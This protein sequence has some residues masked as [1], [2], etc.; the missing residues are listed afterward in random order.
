M[1]ANVRRPSHLTDPS[2]SPSSDGTGSA[3]QQMTAAERL[4]AATASPQYMSAFERAAKDAML[5]ESDQTR[6]A[7]VVAAHYQ[8]GI[9]D[10]ITLN[11]HNKVLEADIAQ[12]GLTPETYAASIG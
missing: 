11:Q 1:T 7:D 6:K 9:K 2:G 3:V 12:S 5:Q 10:L 4:N 8:E